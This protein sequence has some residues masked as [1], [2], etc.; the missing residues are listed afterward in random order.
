[1]N[2]IEQSA[3]LNH[4]RQVIAAEPS[5]CRPVIDA[6]TE[7]VK[8]FADKQ[9]NIGTKACFRLLCVLEQTPSPKDGKFGVF[10]AAE[11]IDALEPN[12]GGTPAI[13]KMREKFAAGASVKEG[14]EK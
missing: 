10:T 2:I 4:V 14:K 5:L 13:A 9:G 3:F 11:V 1:V 8:D 6:A 12:F 7:G